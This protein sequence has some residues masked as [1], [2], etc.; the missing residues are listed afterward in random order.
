MKLSAQQ[1]KTTGPGRH[2]D[3]RGLFL[4]VKLLARGPGCYAIKCKVAGA[5]LVWVLFRT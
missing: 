5:T 2:G 3:G 4:Y 1:V